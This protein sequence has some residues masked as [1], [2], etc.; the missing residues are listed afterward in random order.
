MGKITMPGFAAEAA[1]YGFSPFRNSR[2]HPRVSSGVYRKVLLPLFPDPLLW[3]R[4]V[5]GNRRL[6]R[7][8]AHRDVCF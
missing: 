4:R 1:C 8:G 2:C 6:L 5:G 3:G 7:C